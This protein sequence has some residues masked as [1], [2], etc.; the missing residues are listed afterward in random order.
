MDTTHDLILC[1]S[2][3]FAPA[4]ISEIP[5]ARTVFPSREMPDNRTEL[6]YEQTLG[7][8]LLIDPGPEQGCYE[9][10]HEGCH[11]ID[12]PHPCRDQP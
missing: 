4:P 7:R 8:L 3:F 9:Q 2:A 10:D 6:A 1:L 12:Y 11:S 5:S